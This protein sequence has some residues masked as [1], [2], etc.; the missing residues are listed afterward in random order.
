MVILRKL[1]Q[2]GTLT[3]DQVVELYTTVFL[4]T[5][6]VFRQ[7]VN[8]TTKM[9]EEGLIDCEYNADGDVVRIYSKKQK[10]SI[11]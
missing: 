7:A 1:N 2:T 6:N 5:T 9:D 3:I 4:R 11:L 8:F 10:D